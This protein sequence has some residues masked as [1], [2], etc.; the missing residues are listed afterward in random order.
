MVGL[1]GEELYI[2]AGDLYFRR[3]GEEEF[4]IARK[5][6]RTQ[7]A[8]WINPVKVPDLLEN[9]E[10]FDQYWSAGEDAA[11]DVQA[12]L[13]T[14]RESRGGR[15]SRFTFDPRIDDDNGMAVSDV[16]I[17][18]DFELTGPRGEVFA[19]LAGDH[20]RF[21][22]R[23]STDA[24]SAL[25]YYA[26]GQE[27]G[28]PS[29]TLPLRNF[30]PSMD[31]RHRLDLFVYDGL[32]VVR[33]DGLEQASYEYITTRQSVKQ[34]S[35]FAHELSFGTR[36][37]TAKFRDLS[38]G[39]DIYYKGR[40]DRRPR[41]LAE[42]EILELKDGKYVMMGDNVNNSHDSRAWR[43]CTFLLKDGRTVLCE[44]QEVNNEK[45]ITKK[46]LQKQYGL[47]DEP[48]VLIA[49][50]IYGN[51]WA[52]YS[53]DPGDLKPGTLAGIIDRARQSE[54]D[55]EGQ[56]H[57]YIDQKFIVGKAFWVWWPSGRWFRLIR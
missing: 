17:A 12:G 8:L 30:K 18:F 45:E 25:H 19:D 34:N 46:A 53:H 6:L 5:P 15:G 42:E 13:L 39:R 2:Y 29:V 3:K 43:E 23:L 10:A 4:H 14:T 54:E 37:V 26:P 38:V 48:N 11:Y 31:A 24:P 44:A 49:A 33:V 32:A 7:D 40:G 47:N 50:D 41:G 55:R 20:G 27:K 35:D 28:Q 57:P 16:R 56:P 1:P 21:E 36:D 9:R 51:R 22:V 52:L